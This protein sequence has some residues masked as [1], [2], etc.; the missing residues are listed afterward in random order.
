MKNYAF[1]TNMI[2]G[3]YHGDA[4]RSV[5]P[6]LFQTNAYYYEN[7]QQAQNLFELKET[8]NIYTRITNPTNST[9]EE[10]VCILEGG[11][12]ALSFASGH[13]AIFNC[14]VNLANAGDEVVSSRNIYGGAV[15]LLGVSCERLGIKIRFVDPDDSDAWEAAINDKT[16]LVFTELIGNPHANIS[17]IEQ[18]AKIAHKHGV[19]FLVDG[20]LNTPYLCKPFEFGADFVVHS[21]TKYLGGHGNVMAGVVIDSGNF[22]FKDNPRFPLYNTGDVSYHGLVFA[23]LKPAELGGK[24]LSFILR[25]RALVMRDLGACLAPFNS[26]LTMIGIE[27]LSLRM[28]RCC[29]NALK[30]AEF[31]AS[32]SKVEA[33]N[34]APLPGNK[35]HKL[36]QKYLPKGAAGVFSFRI[37][38]GKPAAVKFMDSL[39]LIQSV[40]NL[41]DIRTQV[42]HPATT[43]HSQMNAEQLAASGIDGGDVR[44]SVGLENI[45]DLIADIENALSKI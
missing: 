45:S 13:A 4:T 22:D 28:E 24:S 9:F 26:F 12:G 3:G 23:D 6:P 7:A 42:S 25:L 40:S 43:T 21:A 44:I 10:R 14:I 18:I 31:L 17:D 29:E 39:T 16:R 1:E 32:H 5:V 2:H 36:A 11:V 35:Y 37:C 19:P 20:T 8:G 38:G 33:V 41:G 15:N 30:A 34:Y 27:T